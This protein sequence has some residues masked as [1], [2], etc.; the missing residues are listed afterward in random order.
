MNRLKLARGI[1]FVVR[2]EFN[3]FEGVEFTRGVLAC[4]I[5]D[6]IVGKIWDMLSALWFTPKSRSAAGPSAWREPALLRRRVP[7]WAPN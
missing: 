4:D 2:F 1:L 6:D 3:V 7:G 5:S